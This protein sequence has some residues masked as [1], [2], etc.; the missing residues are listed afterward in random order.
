[1]TAPKTTTPPDPRHPEDRGRSAN[2][3]K[4]RAGGDDRGRG[5]FET[6]PDV[7]DLTRGAPPKPVKRY[8]QAG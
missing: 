1:M 4:D 5:T 3:G 7:E 2:E 6:G 8:S